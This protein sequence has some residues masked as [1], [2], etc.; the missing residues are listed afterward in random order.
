MPYALAGSMALNMWGAAQKS[1][2]MA[3]EEAAN[4]AAQREMDRLTFNRQQQQYMQ[5]VVGI[6]QQETVDSLNIG[7]AASQAE[8][9][10]SLHKAGSNLAGASINELDAEISREVHNDLMASQR[11]SDQALTNLDQ[12]RIQAN[13]NRQIKANMRRPPDYTKMLSSAFLQSAAS[14]LGRL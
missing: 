3:Q 4:I 14:G 11:Q 5:Q 6:K 7:I 8:S 1:K 13:E 10:L 2:A 9:Q 12:E